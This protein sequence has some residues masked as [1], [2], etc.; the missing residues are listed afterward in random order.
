MGIVTTMTS[1]VSVKSFLIADLLVNGEAECGATDTNKNTNKDSDEKRNDRN[2]D[3]VVSSSSSS[4]GASSP[5]GCPHRTGSATSSRESIASED[6]KKWRN[7]ETPHNKPGNALGSTG[8]LGVYQYP[9]FPMGYAIPEGNSRLGE[10]D[11]G[12]RSY[13]TLFP[14]GYD[15]RHHHGVGYP[16]SQGS[17][18]SMMVPLVGGMTQPG[19]DFQLHH[20]PMYGMPASTMP[21]Y[22]DKGGIHG[23]RDS[24]KKCLFLFQFY[25][26][27][28]HHDQSQSK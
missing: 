10:T 14:V 19:I 2:E 13:Q 22:H 4:S 8:S 11:G 23:G 24:C 5:P 27:R 28:R 25:V 16:R 17:M 3:H 12:G 20:M 7:L 15:Y 9:S 18:G 6:G 21:R 26:I 1:G